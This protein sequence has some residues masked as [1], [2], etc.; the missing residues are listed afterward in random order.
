MLALRHAHHEALELG[1]DLDLTGEPAGGFQL[2]REVEH[3]FFHV[4]LRWHFVGP[5]GIDIDMAG[6]A[7][8]G[9]AAIG[10]DARNQVLDRATVNNAGQVFPI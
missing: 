6:G 9:A 7:G 4:L 1:R 5:G 3:G 10:V 2:L 8:A